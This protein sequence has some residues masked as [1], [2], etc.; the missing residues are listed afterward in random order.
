MAAGGVLGGGEE[1]PLQAAR[2]TPTR[3]SMDSAKTREAKG[4]LKRQ[5]N[6]VRDL[7][8][9]IALDELRVSLSEVLLSLP[10]EPA[11]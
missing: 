7:G 6:E 10:N 8:L 2:P 9:S 3:G 5:L 11:G 4:F 1:F